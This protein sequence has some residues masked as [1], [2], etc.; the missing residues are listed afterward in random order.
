ME[1]GICPIAD[2]AA[3]KIISLSVS[4]KSG[5][6]G[7]TFNINVVYA[8]TNATGTGTVEVDILPPDADPFG[9]AGLIIDYPAGTYSAQMQVQTQPSEQEPFNAGTYQVIAGM[10]SIM[11]LTDFN[12]VIAICEGTCG[13][14]HSHSYI[15]AQGQTLFTITN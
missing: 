15:I 10:I 7:T 12:L 5:K 13:S 14:T 3:G 1:V 2:N 8:I 4:P 9:D 6:A 11:K